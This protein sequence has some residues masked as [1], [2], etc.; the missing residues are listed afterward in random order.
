MIVGKMKL[1]AEIF[2]G[3]EI[4]NA[5]APV[6]V[7]FNDTQRQTTNDAKTILGTEVQRII[8][9]PTVAAIVYDMVKIGGESNVLVFDLGGGTFE[10]TLPTIDQGVFEVSS[11]NGDVK[12]S[13]KGSCSS[14]SRSR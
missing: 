13:I 8:N 4:T 12:V 1:T 10:V 2:L 5:I 14:S 11:T 3:K 7:C 9:N 6:P